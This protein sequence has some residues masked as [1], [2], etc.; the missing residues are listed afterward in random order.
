[1]DGTRDHLLEW[2]KP[3]SKDQ[4]TQ[5]FVHMWNLCLKTMIIIINNTNE[6]RICFCLYVESRSKNN[7]DNN[8]NED[9]IWMLK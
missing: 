1:M 3:S 9:G 6:N 4:A 7:N 2:D 8:N 5:D